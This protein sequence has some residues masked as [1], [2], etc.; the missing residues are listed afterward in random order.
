MFSPY[1]LKKCNRCEEEKPRTEFRYNKKAKQYCYLCKKCDNADR[2]ER[3]KKNREQYRERWNAW[4]WRPEV[5]ERIRQKARE[6]YYKNKQRVRVAVLNR[7][8][9]IKN[10]GGKFTQAQIA[11]MFASQDGECVVCK[12]DISAKYHIDHIVPLAAG[13]SNDISNIQLLCPTCNMRKGRKSMDQFL[14]LMG[15]R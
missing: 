15:A 5:R 3:N 1:S 6:Q 7:I 13:G 2:T 14:S 4:A 12:F 10:A 11:E 9:R 8:A